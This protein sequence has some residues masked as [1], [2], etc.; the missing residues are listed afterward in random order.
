MKLV[1]KPPVILKEGSKRT[2]GE[3]AVRVN[4]AA[5]KV[6]GETLRSTLGPRGMDKMLVDRLGGIVITNDGA[7]ILEEIDVRHPAARI[8]VEIARTQDSEVG[9][10]TT[11]AVL[12]ASELLMRAEALL[13]LKVHPNLIISGYKKALSKSQEILQDLSI[14]LDL[15]DHDTLKNIAKS[16][17]NSKLMRGHEDYFA[18]IAVLSVLR[19]QE[20]RETTSYVDLEK[21][22]IIKHQGTSLTDTLLVDGIILEKEIEHPEMIKQILNAKIALLDMP[23][24]LEKTKFDT[25]IKITT[26]LEIKSYL[27]E[28]ESIFRDMVRKI[29]ESGAN[30]VI[31]Q[32]GMSLLVEHLLTKSNILVVKRIKKKE[33]MKVHRAVGGTII[34][35]IDDLNSGVLGY[36]GNVEEKLI[37]T[38]KMIFIEKCQNPRS[39]SILI[40]GSIEHLLHEVERILIDAM[41]VIADIIKRPYILP[42]GGS[43][44]VELAKKLREYAVAI[45]GR[46]QLAIESFAD[47]LETIPKILAENAGYDPI[48]ILVSLRA[49]HTIEK[50]KYYGIE[51]FTGEIVDMHTHGVLE[52]LLVKVQALKSAVEAATMIL[53]IDDV[54]AA[55]LI[56]P[57][58]RAGAP[59]IGAGQSQP[60]FGQ[61]PMV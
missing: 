21:I 54:V 5:A 7:T 41:S 52:P 18:N 50:N 31:T 30:V 51:V 9:D 47:S 32:K 42:G 6:V 28:E 23:L 38:K 46:E 45:G 4:I 20:P 3:D 13:N 26:P 58:R 44:D 37:G 2:A 11:T 53:K 57:E 49:V 39:V 25:E 22:Q 48:D 15:S 43:I 8:M 14:P 56:A 40:R 16:A 34:S 24:E 19:I 12:L 17:I 36:A 60:N 61:N 35:S 27:D 59:G 29:V 33:M 1:K 10:G 55:K